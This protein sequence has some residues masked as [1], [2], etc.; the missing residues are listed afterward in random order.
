M[1]IPLD[2]SFVNMFE[3]FLGKND[4]VVFKR[5]FVSVLKLFAHF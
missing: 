5:H 4:I 3:M 1:K 2:M